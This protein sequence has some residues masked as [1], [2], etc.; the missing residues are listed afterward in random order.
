MKSV[1]SLMPFST[2]L[3]GILLNTK[4]IG[5][6]DAEGPENYNN[7]EMKSGRLLTAFTQHLTPAVENLKIIA[8]VDPSRAT[9]SK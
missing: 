7:A 8:K 9:N 3:S 2:G 4:C 5:V 6:I 1:T